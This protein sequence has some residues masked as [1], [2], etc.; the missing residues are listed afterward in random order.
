[1]TRPSNE[2]EFT[3]KVKVNT[4]LEPLKLNLQEKLSNNIPCNQKLNF[5]FIV[6]LIRSSRTRPDNIKLVS[7]VQTVVQ[8]GHGARLHSE[9][10]TLMTAG[11]LSE[12]FS[13]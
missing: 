5:D 13:K 9:M 12:T 2:P 1:M 7:L 10:S 6:L 3:F 4:V 11:R 8:L